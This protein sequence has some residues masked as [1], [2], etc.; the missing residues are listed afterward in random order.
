M[1][2][3][4]QIRVCD[5]C[6]KAQHSGRNLRIK[7]RLRNLAGMQSKQ[8]EILSPGMNYFFHL[9]I[10]DQFPKRGERTVGLDGGKI[11]DGRNVLS[12]HLDEF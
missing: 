6:P 10:A 8:I 1:D 4:D 9:S 12:G 5:L 7:K 2:P 3:L 11:N